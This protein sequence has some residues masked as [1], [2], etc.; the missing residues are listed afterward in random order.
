MAEIGRRRDRESTQREV[1]KLRGS[2]Q[3]LT[4]SANPLGK[5]MDF[6]QVHASSDNG[7][8]NPCEMVRFW[9][10]DV[11]SMQRELDTWKEENQRLSMAL[12]QEEAL[13]QK[14]IEPLKLHLQDLDAA[15]QEQLDRY[16]LAST[17]GT[18]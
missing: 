18:L 12:K 15:I 3:T 6:L 5:L 8:N 10:E 9:Q 13:T 7:L 11:D 2:I 1:D 14:S 4:R 16:S 17:V